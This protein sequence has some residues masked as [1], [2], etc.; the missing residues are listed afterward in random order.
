[1]F[2]ECGNLLISESKWPQPIQDGKLN[3]PFDLDLILSDRKRVAS[4]FHAV[5]LLK[6]SQNS[7]LKQQRSA[8][9]EN[10]V[11]KLD[12]EYQSSVRLIDVNEGHDV[13]NYDGEES[14]RTFLLFPSK[15]SIPLSQVSNKIK[16]LVVLDCKWTKTSIQ[17]HLQLETIQHVHLD[18][19]PSE[20]FY[21]RWHNAGKGMCS[22][23]EAIYFAA[24]QVCIANNYTAK[25]I[26]NLIHIMWLF[27]IQRSLTIGT[28][29]REGK[30]NPFST[31][32]KE[33][34][35]ALRKTIKGSEKHIRDIEN[36][37]MFKKG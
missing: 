11:E 10:Q 2:C 24:L 35:R 4:G 33:L 26:D 21:W 6:A 1:M 22:T 20:S 29:I 37:K 14:N 13:P 12:E 28:A 30:P 18:F 17:S 32:A 8:P 3:L 25:D 27:G 34:Q 16:K 31:E 19:V 5:V 23:L 36:G 9:N 15:T 7:R